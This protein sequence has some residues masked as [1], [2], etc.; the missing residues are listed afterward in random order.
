VFLAEQVAGGLIGDLLDVAVTGTCDPRAGG[1]EMVILGCHVFDMLRMLVG[2]EAEWCSA[3]ILQGGVEAGPAEVRLPGQEVYTGQPLKESIGPASRGSQG[4]LDA[5][6][7]ISRV[8]IYTK[9]DK[10][11]INDSTAY[12]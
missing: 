9:Y 5:P 10:A 11:R 1:E 2:A 6:C 3:R 4:H 7:F 12:D 8:I